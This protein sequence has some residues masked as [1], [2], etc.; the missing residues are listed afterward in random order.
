MNHLCNPL[1]TT[2]VRQKRK[3]NC[4]TCPPNAND[5]AEKVTVDG[6]SSTVIA[7]IFAHI[8]F[9]SPAQISYVFNFERTDINP[10]DQK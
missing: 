2:D 5:C 8:K 3:K 9:R 1:S 4:T 6:I 10:G 7:L